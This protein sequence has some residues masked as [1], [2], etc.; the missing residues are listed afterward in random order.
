[1]SNNNFYDQPSGNQNLQSNN[2]YGG[3]GG[4]NAPTSYGN[5]QPQYGY[6]QPQQQHDGY[7]P[8]P[9]PPPGQAPLGRSD[10]FKEGDFVP[11]G[12]RGE[13]REAMQQ[14]EMN[15]SGHESK[16]DRDVATLQQEYPTIDSSLVA[17]LYSDTQD[18]GATREMLQ[19]LVSQNQGGQGS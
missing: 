9:G 13:Q 18:T 17:A 11:A 14:F 10:T 16:E 12:E 2:P 5:T 6:A 19:E 15:K 8:P 3:A 7:A 4:T 1:M